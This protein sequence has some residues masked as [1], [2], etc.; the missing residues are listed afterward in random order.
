MAKF[1][2]I[3]IREAGSNR[4]AGNFCSTN[5]AVT[6]EEL[7]ILAHLRTLRDQ[8]TLLKTELQETAE[9]EARI[10]LQ[11]QLNALRQEAIL[12]REKKAQATYQ[13]HVALGH[14][15]P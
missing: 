11:D 6:P 9:G 4:L 8:A 14:S 13:K 1:I 3:P 5:D 7:T 15:E 10:K 12:W 2:T